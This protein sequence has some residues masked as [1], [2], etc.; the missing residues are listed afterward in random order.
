M[1]RTILFL[2]GHLRA[3]GAE[4]SLVEILRHL[5]YERFEVDLLLFEDYGEYVDELPVEVNLHL[6]DLTR[7]SGP[8]LS[9]LWANVKRRDWFSIAMRLIVG[10]ERITGSRALA[11]ARSIVALRPSYDCAIAFRPGFCADFLAYAVRADRKVVWWHHGEFNFDAAGE[12]GLRDTFRHMD[13]VVVVSESSRALLHRRHLE[14]D[15]K[16]VVI[17][18]M[19][20]ADDIRKR[21]GQ[22]SL[23]AEMPGGEG[24]TVVSV[25]RLS[26]EKSMID[27][28]GACKLLVDRGYRI[29]W[30]LVGAGDERA[31]IERAIGAHDLAGHVFLL[32]SVANPYPIMARADILVHPSRV[33]SFALTVLE[34]LALGL[35]AVVV[36]SS[37]PV[38]YLEDRRH[39]ILVEPGAVAIADGVENLIRDDGLRAA[40]KTEH[41]ALLERYSPSVV[42][43]Q[44][45]REVFSVE[46]DA[47]SSDLDGPLARG[48][49]ERT[50][51]SP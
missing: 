38:E 50:S 18:N 31:R 37:G 41:T 46:S 34:A 20:S 29:R 25:G 3:G 12:V 26:P 10:L 32:G 30:Y 27:C 22:S 35:P 28:V 42:M 9:S 49:L 33:E 36:R 14:I 15:A 21:A 39:A 48:N 6:V 13:R 19:I 5:D 11:L 43:S 8:M 7:A 40:L 47:E 1:K 51:P 23:P 2:N 4:R 16:M 24:L 44:I 17:P 45:E